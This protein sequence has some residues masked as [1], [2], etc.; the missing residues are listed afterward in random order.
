MAR[1]GTRGGRRNRQN[2][3]IPFSES[4]ALLAPGTVL[5]P[6]LQSELSREFE[7]DAAV[8]VGGGRVSHIRST[9]AYPASDANTAIASY[10]HVPWAHGVFGA[11]KSAASLV[12]WRFLVVRDDTG[13]PVKRMDVV[14]SFGER[15]ADL[16]KSIN[17]EELPEDH[18]LVQLWDGTGTPFVSITRQGLTHLYMDTAGECFW[19]LDRDPITKHPTRAWPV[20][21]MWMTVSVNKDMR[22]GF[23]VNVPGGSPFFVAEENTIH[24]CDP[25]PIDPYGRGAGLARAMGA[26][27]DIDMLSSRHVVSHLANRARPDLI[28]S[29]DGLTKHATEQLESRWT[30]ATSGYL[31]TFMPFFVGRKVDVKELSSSFASMELT[32]LRESVRDATQQAAG[33]PPP[34]IGVFDGMTETGLRHSE[35]LFSRWTLTPRLEML[36]QYIQAYLVPQYDDRIIATY[37]NPVL[38]DNEFALRAMTVMPDTVKVDEWRKVQRLTPLGGEE[39]NAFLKSHRRTVSEEIIDPPEEPTKPEPVIGKK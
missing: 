14:R 26:H 33:V 32:K 17:A 5:T 30:N 11:I 4:L 18:P 20:P 6:E 25:D 37:D 1:R 31:N 23:D 8:A 7:P 21:P 10:N 35:T 28:V 36:R 9:N 15:H 39:G 12:R 27:F 3:R 19:I 22:R 13:K 24:F 2:T 29:A 34:M 38:E 16:V